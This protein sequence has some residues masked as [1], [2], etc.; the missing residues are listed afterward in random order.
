MTT[1]RGSG[2]GR[3]P[4]RGRVRL[5]T[6]L[7][8][9]LAALVISGVGSGAAAASALDVVTVLEQSGQTEVV[10]QI[11]P[12]PV[13]ALPSDAAH[14]TVDGSDV[15]ATVRPL[16][17]TDAP[18]ALVVDASAAAGGALAQEL[19]G[20]AGLLLRLPSTTPV[21]VVADQGTPRLLLTAGSPAA[22]IHALVGLTPGGE[23]DTSA[24]LDLA[25]RSVGTAA[26]P[27]SP[28]LLLVATR[29]AV[30]GAPQDPRLARRLSASGAVLAVVAD[31]SV[32]SGWDATA[33]A[34]GGVSVAATPAQA[35]DAFN[36]LADTLRARCL[37]RFAAPAAADTAH[38]VLR[39]GD[40]EFAADVSL[41]GASA[42]A[43]TI[44][45]AAPSGAGATAPTAT[46]GGG[47]EAT[48]E[49]PGV[50]LG[51]GLLAAVVVL[52]VVA[53]VVVT[54]RRRSGHPRA[55]GVTAPAPSATPPTSAQISALISARTPAR[56]PAPTAAPGPAPTSAPGPAP[57]SAAGP[58]PTSISV[59]AGEDGGAMPP[60]VRFFDLSDPDHPT[61]L[62]P[63]EAAG[64]AT[65]NGHSVDEGVP[66]DVRS[67]SEEHGEPDE[68]ERLEE[69]ADV[70]SPEPAPEEAADVETSER[71]P[72]EPADVET[73]EPGPEAVEPEAVEPEA[74]EPE[75][76][77]P[78]PVEPEPVEPEPVAPEAVEPEAVEPEG[79]EPEAVEP[80]PVAAGGGRAGAGRA[81]G[82]RA[83]AG[84]AGAGRAAA[85]RA[86]G[87]R[88]GAGRAGGSGAAVGRAGGGRAGAG[89]A[90]AGRAG[91]GR[92]GVGRAGGLGPRPLRGATPRAGR[93]GGD[94]RRR[95]RVRG[96]L[97]SRPPS[98]HATRMLGTCRP[99]RGQPG[100]GQRAVRALPGCGPPA[101]SVLSPEWVHFNPPVVIGIRS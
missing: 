42:P 26:S 5:V 6:G 83:G 94:G 41:A 43:P 75:A 85:G 73:P 32:A 90:G 55:A 99:G 17:A 33:R 37:V 36:G 27:Q 18:V 24:A 92:A 87:R 59:S 57:T 14:V 96:E 46:A 67:E 53:A 52:G 71:E 49:G 65:S 34:T 98:P 93:G 7:L 58:V 74:V 70:E 47:S 100:H 39:V 28:G 16:L 2:R 66:A 82:R 81:R 69:P 45:S 11:T 8:A 62:G 29:G 89:R 54:R 79:L 44:A 56:G 78:E 48:S 84:R 50:A 91:V 88:A 35:P 68:P 15:P 60:G 40:Q 86:G 31:P 23:R 76:V 13:A 3:G 72:E 97:S 12:D 20:A 77:E 38:V 61:E 63:H 80:E 51:V 101:H 4:G 25:V 22:A 1:A 21:T 95:R 64:S 10:A 9:V 30:P 19:S